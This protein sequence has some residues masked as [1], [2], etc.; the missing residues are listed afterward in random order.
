M[1]RNACICYDGALLGFKMYVLG[2]NTKSV[3]KNANCIFC[4]S[5]GS[6]KSVIIIPFIIREYFGW[7]WLHQ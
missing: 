1:Q 3:N 5:A 7:I 2:K 6:A 4:T